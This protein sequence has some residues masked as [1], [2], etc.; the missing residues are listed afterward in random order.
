M[1]SGPLRAVPDGLWLVLDDF[2]AQV[3]RQEVDEE[4][5]AELVDDIL[6]SSLQHGVDLVFG[7]VAPV[8][9]GSLGPLEKLQEHWR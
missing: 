5:H 8:G 3:E 4:R 7:V 2:A 6:V 9:E 1:V